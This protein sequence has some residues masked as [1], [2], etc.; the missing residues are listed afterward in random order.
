[1]AAIS[2][3]ASRSASAWPWPAYPAPITSARSALANAAPHGDDRVH[4][5]GEVRKQDVRA[6]RVRPVLGRQIA[7]IPH[8][9]KR[10]HHFA[11]VHVALQQHHEPLDGPDGGL[12]V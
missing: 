3:P 10:P 8:I 6:V 5:R 7:V 2:A 12:E 9:P 1:M 4:A 11:P